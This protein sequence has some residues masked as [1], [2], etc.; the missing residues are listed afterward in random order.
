LIEENVLFQ[1]TESLLWRFVEN[2]PRGSWANHNSFK[3]S[4]FNFL[5][6]VVAEDETALFRISKYVENNL[7]TV[8]QIVGVAKQLEEMESLL[9]KEQVKAA[10]Y[11]E[12]LESILSDDLTRTVIETNKNLK[13]EFGEDWIDSFL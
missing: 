2:P 7:S 11:K 5:K 6:K 3:R 12:Q 4:Y 13:N 1:K 8:D 9:K 10:E